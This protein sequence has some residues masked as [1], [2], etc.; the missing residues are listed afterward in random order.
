MSVVHDL[1]LL[2]QMVLKVTMVWLPL[3]L[4]LQLAVGISQ[5]SAVRAGW[6]VG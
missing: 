6:E 4:A 2:V 5:Q 1:V 3:V